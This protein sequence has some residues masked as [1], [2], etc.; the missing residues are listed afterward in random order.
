MTSTRSQL[1]SLASLGLLLTAAF[2]GWSAST[3]ATAAETSPS[4]ATGATEVVIAPGGYIRLPDGPQLTFVGVGEDSRCPKDALCTWPGQA[5]LAFNLKTAEG[6]AQDFQVTYQGHAT[7]ATIAGSAVTVS[8]VQPY[9][10]SAMPIE[11]NDYRVTASIGAVVI[12]AADFGGTVNVNVGQT[13]IVDPGGDYV[14]YIWTATAADPTVLEALPQI[15]IFPP[16]PPAFIATARGVT[17]LS[18]VR[19]DP[20]R[21]SDPPCL[22]PE[23]LFEVQVVVL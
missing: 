4:G 3:A 17:T 16:P 13:V 20:C 2:G 10:V 22:L 21:Y 11:P 1:F 23:Q 12:T 15:L 9:P 19:Q 8:D 6:N 14:D 5:V 7:T 18:I